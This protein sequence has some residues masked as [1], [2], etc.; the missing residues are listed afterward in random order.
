MYI[1][2]G[3]NEVFGFITMVFDVDNMLIVAK[4]TSKVDK[5]KA[6]L[7]SELQMKDLCANRRIFEM[8]IHEDLE[9]GKL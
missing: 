5:L 9:N 6:Q 1:K 7:S 8:E 4:D 3:S 2:H